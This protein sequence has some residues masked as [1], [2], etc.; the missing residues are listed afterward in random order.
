MEF[1]DPAIEEY[2]RAFSD[3]ESALLKELDRETHALILQ[4]RMLSGHLQGSFYPLFQRFGGPNVFWK[5]VPIR[6]IRR[7]VWRKA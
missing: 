3:P 6:V 2:S 7:F 1:I 4:P 5:S